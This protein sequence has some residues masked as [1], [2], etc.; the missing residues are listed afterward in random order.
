MLPLALACRLQLILFR[1]PYSPSTFPARSDV[2]LR[3][4]RR[5]PLTVLTRRIPAT[6]RLQLVRVPHPFGSA[7][8]SIACR[9]FGSTL[10]FGLCVSFLLVSSSL[11][12]PRVHTSSSSC[13]PHAPRTY[14]GDGVFGAA[15]ARSPRAARRVSSF[16]RPEPGIPLRSSP[17]SSHP[18][19]SDP[20]RRLVVFVL[21]L[22]PPGLTAAARLDAANTAHS[23]FV[24]GNM[25]PEA[26]YRRFI[27]LDLL[28]SPYPLSLS[29]S[30][31]LLRVLW[32]VRLWASVCVCV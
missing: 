28:N 22:R 16:R 5:V 19:A 18:L 13:T 30:L 8:P 20:S 4:D 3:P 21:P 12:A 25:P 17:R 6:T 11:S 32:C 23:G 14:A 2:S 9:R 26:N 31:S 7:P 24:G 10:P 15:P 29:L 27:Q 1:T